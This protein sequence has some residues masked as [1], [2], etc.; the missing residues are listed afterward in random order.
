M[1][2]EMH[3]GD[4]FYGKAR[5]NRRRRNVFEAKKQVRTC[6]DFLAGDWIVLLLFW[7]SATL[8]AARASIGSKTREF[9]LRTEVRGRGCGRAERGQMLAASEVGRGEG[10]RWIERRRVYGAR[11]IEV[12]RIGG[13]HRWV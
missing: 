3:T 13:Q 2:N 7:R 9:G 6:L 4:M 8:D 12:A 10:A 5:K 11:S 1:G